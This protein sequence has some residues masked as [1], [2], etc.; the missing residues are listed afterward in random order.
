MSPFTGSS[1]LYSLVALFSA[2]IL[3]LVLVVLVTS[4]AFFTI[5]EVLFRLF[6]LVSYCVTIYEV[7]KHTVVPVAHTLR[8]IRFG[9][10]ETIS[11]SRT[12]IDQHPGS[13]PVDLRDPQPRYRFERV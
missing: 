2:L 12:W 6:Q 4:G 1:G 10:Q 8:E 11:T 9:R 5:V 3:S 7:F 13:S